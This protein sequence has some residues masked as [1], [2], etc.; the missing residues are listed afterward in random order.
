MKRS[1]ALLARRTLIVAMIER[2]RGGQITS[3]D[4]SNVYFEYV[5]LIFKWCEVFLVRQFDSK[6]CSRRHA[7]EIRTRVCSIVK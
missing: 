3:S 5:F 4:R 1:A 2:G 7:H 6:R